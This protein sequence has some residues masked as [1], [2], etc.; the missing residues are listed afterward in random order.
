MV[1]DGP[2]E[3]HGEKLAS[4]SNFHAFRGPPPFLELE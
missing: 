2:W 3:H 4:K 1:G